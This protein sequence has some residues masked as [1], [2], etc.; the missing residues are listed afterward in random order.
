MLGRIFGLLLIT[1]ATTSGVARAQDSWTDRRVTDRARERAPLLVGARGSATRARARAEGV[2][3]Y[4][5]PSVDY[6][7]QESFAPNAQA[8]DLLRVVVPFDLS[9]RR[10]AARL[11]AE[12]S[13]DELETDAS[14]LGLELAAQALEQFY[15]ALAAERRVTLLGEAQVILDEA[16][17]ILA[18]RQAAGEASGYERARLSLEAELSRSGLARATLDVSVST[19]EL[20]GLLGEPGSVGSLS[21]DFEVAPPA[22]LDE[23]LRRA[24]HDR[25][26]LA[27]LE[28]RLAIARSARSAA[29]TAWIPT[30]ALFGGYNRQEGPLVGHGYSVGLRLDI[31]LFDRGQGE[32]AEAS[33]AVAA[34]EEYGD[35]LRIAVRARVAAARTQLEGMLAERARFAESTGE[36]TQLLVRAATSGFQGGERSLVE[37]LDARRAALD[38][39]ERRLALDLAV[40]LA[41]VEL[42][43]AT[44]IR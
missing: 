24:A 28:R 40:R 29:E 11:L 21:G 1:I 8:Q 43:R 17:R 32:Q 39:A 36:A 6:E 10:D 35:V 33:A 34:L 14:S 2:G 26:D 20:A 9:G 44:G 3:L 7:R 13:A 4:P 31:P 42:R 37:L 25:P 30:F 19:Q 38:V 18:S 15:R 41:D 27:S 5:N 12:L 16:A 22:S 23:L